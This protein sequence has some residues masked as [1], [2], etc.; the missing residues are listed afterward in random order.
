MR[1]G[2]KLSGKPVPDPDHGG[3]AAFL[4]QKA[5]RRVAYTLDHRNLGPVVHTTTDLRMP[6]VMGVTRCRT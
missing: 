3:A 1:C 6:L 5:R 2:R 4:R